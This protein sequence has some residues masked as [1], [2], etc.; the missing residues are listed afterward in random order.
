[1]IADC[2]PWITE[3]G[4]PFKSNFCFNSNPRRCKLCGG[5]EVTIVSI[6]F[7]TMYFSKNATEGFTQKTRASG[8][9]RL[10]RIQRNTLSKK[11]CFFWL[12]I[13][14]EFIFLVLFFERKE[15]S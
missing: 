14:P 7:S 10:P 13:I 6:L 1:M 12:G 15:A 2:C 9:K 8:I 3:I 5:P 4:K 11:D